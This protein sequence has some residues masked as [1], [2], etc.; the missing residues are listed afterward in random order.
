MIRNLLPKGLEGWLSRKQFLLPYYEAWSLHLSTVG[1]SQTHIP[2]A[3]RGI[4]P[5]LGL[6]GHQAHAHTFSQACM[7]VFMDISTN[8]FL[9]AINKKFICL[10]KS[11]C[12]HCPENFNRFIYKCYK[13]EVLKCSRFACISAL[14][15]AFI[16]R[17]HTQMNMEK[18]PILDSG[19]PHPHVSTVNPILRNFLPHGKN[20]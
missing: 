7:Y 19:P 13:V 11:K 10:K 6:C 9:V 15:L 2:P 8:I 12:W 20:I 5:S 4:I 14:C 16:L 18:V 1:R 17:I 3:P